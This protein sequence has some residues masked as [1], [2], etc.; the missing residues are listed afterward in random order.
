MMRLCLVQAVVKTANVLLSVRLFLDRELCKAFRFEVGLKWFIRCKQ[1][2]SKA[3]RDALYFD[4]I[5][6]RKSI[7]FVLVYILFLKELNRTFDKFKKIYQWNITN[8]ENVI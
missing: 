8:I 4:E 7:L 6:I 1:E 5:L 3:L 2:Q